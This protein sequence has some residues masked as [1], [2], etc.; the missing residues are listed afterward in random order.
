METGSQSSESFST[1]NHRDAGGTA[2][3]A[4]NTPVRARTPASR[5]P[6]VGQEH[7]E[8][9]GQAAAPAPVTPPQAL[10]LMWRASMTAGQPAPAVKME[11]PVAV[12]LVKNEPAF[13]VAV[14]LVKHEP[15]YPRWLPDDSSLTRYAQVQRG[16]SRVSLLCLPC[17]PQCLSSPCF[18]SGS[19]EVTAILHVC[20]ASLAPHLEGDCLQSN[21]PGARRPS[22]QSSCSPFIVA[23]APCAGAELSLREGDVRAAPV[24]HVAL[25]RAPRRACT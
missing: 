3:S 21:A 23:C 15:P 5:S 17:P 18:S 10:S 11:A 6:A 7:E 19:S 24:D 20:C 25:Q 1:C 9:E 13:P 16:A 2:I 4:D 12:N 22:S 8:V 14:D